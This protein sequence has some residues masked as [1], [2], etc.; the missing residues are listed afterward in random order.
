MKM[1]LSELRS[2]VREVIILEYSPQPS[3]TFYHRS[4]A[5]LKVGQVLTAQVNKQ[6]G[7][8]WLRS[9]DF[10]VALD[11][12]RQKNHPDLPSRFDCVYASL[13]PH[14][15]FLG[16]GR[17]YRIEPVNCVPFVTNSRIIDE[18]IAVYPD[19]YDYDT[20]PPRKI[21][22][23]IDEN[24][25]LFRDYWN[26]DDPTK[27]NL[28][29]L[30]VLMKSARVIELIDEKRALPGDVFTLHV[31]VDAYVAIYGDSVYSSNG[32]DTVSLDNCIKLL[33]S[34]PYVEINKGQRDDRRL[35]LRLL[36][37]FKSTI[38]R[39]YSSMP[40]DKAER[41]SD[42][43]QPYTDN[44]SSSIDGDGVMLTLDFRDAKMFMKSLRAG[45]ITL[46][47]S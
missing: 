32:K 14:S 22:Q 15:R 19:E 3:A 9:K 6:S 35:P 27:K 5:Q 38:R 8:H 28:P 24:D 25:R 29:D 2:L 21:K 12:Y 34:T 41:P 44:F 31:P 4:S 17:L 37:G 42:L 47:K 1:K 18:L 45:D 33:D 20:M 43:R 23:F 26:G 10:E 11:N 16:K 36:P 40:G 13:T 30:E 39:V 46:D 7:Q